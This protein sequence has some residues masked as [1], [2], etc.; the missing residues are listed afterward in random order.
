MMNSH[1]SSVIDSA[2]QLYYLQNAK[3]HGAPAV[4]SATVPPAF[5]TR[6]GFVKKCEEENA[7]NM[8]ECSLETTRP[9]IEH[10]V[11]P[12]LADLKPITLRGVATKVNH[13]HKDHVLFV[14]VIHAP[15]RVIATH[16][17]VQ[18]DDDNCLMLALYNFI[19]N[20]EVPNDVFRVGTH[21]ALLAPYMKNSMDNRSLNLM[22]RCDNPQCVVKFDSREAWLA[23]KEWK[24]TRIEEGV[25]SELRQRGN[26]EFR[27]GNFDVA[28]RLYSTALRSPR[29]EELDKIACL[30]NLAAV[31]LR[32]ERWEDVECYTQQVLLIDN[33]HSKA[34]FRLA[35]ALMR[36]GKSSEALVI[37]ADLM[38]QNK[39]DS[40]FQEL[41]DEGRRLVQ[42]EEGRYDFR[43]MREEASSQKA[44][45]FHADF[46]SP[47]V[48]VGASIETV[49][50]S[51]YRGCKAVKDIM[52][53]ELLSSSKAFVFAPSTE[54]GTSTSL[55]VDAYRH[56]VNKQS[57]ILLV[58]HV[59]RALRNR[60]T[61]GRQFYS[62]DAGND[63]SDIQVADNDKIDLPRIRCIL[64]SNVFSQTAESEDVVSSLERL[65][66]RRRQGPSWTESEAKK[67]KNGSGLWLRESMFN[68]SCIP[69]CTWAQI[70]DQMFIRSAR[71]IMSNEE[72]CISYLFH[73]FGFQKRQQVFANWTKPGKGFTCACEWCHLLR[74]KEQ[75]RQLEA[76]VEVAYQK[77]YEEVSLKRVPLAVAVDAA[78]SPHRR[79]YI[80]SVF[81]PLPLRLQ[82]NT[83]AKL[84]VFAGA[85]LQ[86]RGDNSGAL[87]AY[88]RAGDI[89]FAVRGGGG[90]ERAQDLW[91]VAGAAMACKRKERTVE[92]LQEIWKGRGFEALSSTDARVA[93]SELTIHYS[94][95]WW[96]G[97]PDF[98]RK[99]QMEMLVKDVCSEK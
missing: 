82:H 66:E 68:H 47:N 46:I 67:L 80:M 13:I 43:R 48:E 90:M 15:Y 26:N 91:C 3:A 63:I 2:N 88:E 33:Q 40:S 55:E 61:L 19:Q 1:W 60:P 99:H 85:C 74:T 62:L 56:M 21:L 71:P 93:F 29:I 45:Q 28:A 72:L 17:L 27:R 50:G 16:V 96:T 78:M 86:R 7:K 70:G 59:I 97:C 31:G 37:A 84:E 52:A 77:A 87:K 51:R 41:V 94:L 25:P 39:R 57:D 14:T 11:A 18:D 49:S 42:E 36:L 83:I 12:S 8:N 54:G 92:A 38:N 4:Y 64:N 9:S 79:K 81:A 69:N 23:A 76:E 44:K 73:S 58:H 20:D 89:G 24:P 98:T 95:P 22:L 53:D 32:K 34:R 5:M 75:L 30:S 6:N 65:L 35:K 10:G